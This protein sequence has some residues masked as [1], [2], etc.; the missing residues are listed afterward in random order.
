MKT[1]ICL[2]CDQQFVGET[3]EEVMHAMMP[4]YMERHKDI[5]EAGDDTKKKEWFVEFERRWNDA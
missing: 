3:K 2:D 1:I 5:M 4:H